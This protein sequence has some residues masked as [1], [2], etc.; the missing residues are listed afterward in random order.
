MRRS[1]WRLVARSGA[2][3]ALLASVAGTA[4][5]EGQ[6]LSNRGVELG[7]SYIGEV[8]GDVSGGIRHGATYEGRFDLDAN[9][10]LG[11]LIGW[12]GAALHV[13]AYQINGYGPSAHYVGN[14]MDVSNIEA[15]PT[16]RLY[17]L[18]IQKEFLGG[19][20]ALRVGQL[21]AD[22]DFLLSDTASTLINGTFAWA[23][24]AA[25]DQTAAGP[26]YPLATP[27]IRLRVMPRHDVVLLLGH[28]RAIQRA[29]AAATTR[30]GATTMVRTSA[31]AAARC[32]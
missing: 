14:L 17:A 5:A 9:V 25:S 10:D 27:G 18:W 6:G 13:S 32:G 8:I 31:L 20:A 7:L 1:A 15:L 12:S 23:T 2:I 16:A 29:R 11:K 24:L 26:A 28:M 30:K 4:R 3:V 21:G 19:R 22:E